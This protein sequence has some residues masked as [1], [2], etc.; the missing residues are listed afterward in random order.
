MRAGSGESQKE[1][2]LRD[3]GAEAEG[4][5]GGS[6]AVAW[7]GRRAGG[8]GAEPQSSRGMIHALH[9]EQRDRMGA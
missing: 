1:A 5:V 7:R 8:S 9:G 4:N 3:V 2:L 6:H